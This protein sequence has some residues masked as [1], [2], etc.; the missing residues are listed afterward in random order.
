M[1]KLRPLDL[2][3][4]EEKIELFETIG[5]N[6]QMSDLA[7]I[8]GGQTNDNGY[9]GYYTMNDGDLYKRM[10]ASQDRSYRV[11][12]SPSY[13]NP[14]DE[15]AAYHD[16]TPSE[17]DDYNDKIEEI[18]TDYVFTIE[19]EKTTGKIN[20]DTTEIY[21]YWSGMRPIVDTKRSNNPVWQTK[22]RNEQGV[23]EVYYGEYPQIATD[24][25]TQQHLEEL[26]KAN[27]LG[28][29]DKKYTIVTNDDLDNSEE[30]TS[31]QYQEYVTDDGRKFIRTSYCNPEDYCL[32]NNT[33]YQANSHE[34]IWVEVKPIKWFIDEKTGLAISSTI[35]LAGCPFKNSNKPYDGSYEETDIANAFWE[36]SK[37]IIPSKIHKNSIYMDGNVVENIIKSQKIENVEETTRIK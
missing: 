27:L 23:L 24:M 20:I 10:Q 13:Y 17:I 14:L 4:R 9:G 25:A 34:L 36:M 19:P 33:T 26:Y 8:F 2:S 30:F 12:N 29:T 7:K 37:D 1:E 5:Y 16:M 18:S 15:D 21:S 35:L 11:A 32:S 3:K 28:T 22:T 31:Q 6:S